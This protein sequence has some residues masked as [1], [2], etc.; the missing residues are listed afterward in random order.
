MKINFDNLPAGMTMP[1]ELE[2]LFEWMDEKNYYA[3]NGI[4]TLLDKE[5]NG[6]DICFF[7]QDESEIAE[8]KVPSK[9]VLD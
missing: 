1:H 6:T 3:E 5:G 7:K 4:I 9:K 2:L 8:I